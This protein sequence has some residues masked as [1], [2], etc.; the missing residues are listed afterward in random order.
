MSMN[1]H[2]AAPQDPGAAAQPRF[3][4]LGTHWKALL[5]R[6][7]LLLR[8]ATAVGASVLLWSV[9]LQPALHTRREAQV[10]L[11][12]LQ[13]QLQTMHALQE[14]AAQVRA[15]PALEPGQAQ[16]L[17]TQA[18][19]THGIADTPLRPDGPST[20][21]IQGLEPEALGH[22]LEALRTDVRI[23]PIRVQLRRDALGLWSGTVQVQGY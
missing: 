3:G 19:R 8:A 14:Q 15:M 18:C 17:F 2:P 5:P 7:R 9:G 4:W 10:A 12:R 21:E 22:W 20:V 13:A 16:A 11:P 6:E 1:K 23:R